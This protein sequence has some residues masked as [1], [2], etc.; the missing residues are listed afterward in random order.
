[1]HA[2]VLPVP[3]L[4]FFLFIPRFITIQASKTLKRR[5][6][7]ELWRPG[8]YLISFLNNVIPDHFMDN[9]RKKIQARESLLA[10]MFILSAIIIETAFT[11]GPTWYWLLILNIPAILLLSG[12][13]KFRRNRTNRNLK[14]VKQMQW[15]QL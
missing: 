12:K 10:I 4:N 9:S 11:R 13:L 3:S 1:M 5:S 14:K 15:Q 6:R 2:I 8:C 7:P